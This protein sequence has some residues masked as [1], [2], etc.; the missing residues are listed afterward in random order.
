ML[1]VCKKHGLTKHFERKDVNHKYFRCGKCSS[2]W[3]TN[4]RI[5]KKKELVKMF[6]GA[7]KICGYKKYV[8]ALDFHHLNPKT[9][10]FALSVK[11][12]SYSW[13]SILKEAKKCI[14]LCKNCHTE[15]ENRITKLD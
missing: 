10:S 8:G 5:K 3:I 7:C 1:K 9:K 15:I 14:M 11:G 4:N 12:L 6:G 2:Q 13:D